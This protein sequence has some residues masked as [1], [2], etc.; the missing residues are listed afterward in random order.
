MV[1]VITGFT[2]GLGRALALRMA[3]SGHTIVGCG[4]SEAAVQELGGRLGG[5]HRCEVVDVSDSAAT[6]RWA[7]ASIEALGAPDLVINNAAIINRNA[8]LWEVDAAA[9]DQLMR[10]NVTGTFHVIQAFLPAMIAR[11]EGVIVNMSSG[12]GRS[13][14]PEVAPYCTSKWAIEGMTRALAQ[15]LPDG[16]AAVSVNPGVID[17]DML[18][19]CWGDQ[20]G[21][22]P[23][24][25]QWVA[26][27]APFFE[28]LAARD[29]GRAL[30]V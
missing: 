21:S 23:G 14:S 20:A 1:I 15:E 18:R 2:K 17:T 29:N 5:D 12:W 13:T 28:G 11:G 19:S 22:F 4:R 30:S 7:T 6:Q 27:A 10:I 25:K 8:P 26:Q 3:K 24:P 9:F 16:L